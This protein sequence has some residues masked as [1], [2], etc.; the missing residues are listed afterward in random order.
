MMNKERVCCICNEHKK[1]LEYYFSLDLQNQKNQ[2]LT[3]Q[4]SK[5]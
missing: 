4:I 1:F 3:K 2:F 5:N